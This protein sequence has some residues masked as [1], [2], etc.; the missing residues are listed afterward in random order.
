M[1]CSDNAERF[2]FDNLLSF[3][4]HSWGIICTLLRIR[5][6]VKF[7]NHTLQLPG[8]FPRGG[9]GSFP[10]SETFGSPEISSKN[11]RKI[12]I[13]KEICIT[14][15]FTPPKK[16]LLEESQLLVFKG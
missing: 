3:M 7:H 13:P 16:K 5:T 1:Y 12:S 2:Q 14:I 9:G 15:D 8:F 11:K 6:A 4:L 10:P